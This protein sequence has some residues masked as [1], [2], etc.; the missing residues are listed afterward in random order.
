MHA[1]ILDPTQVSFTFLR[2][3]HRTL[4]TKLDDLPIELDIFITWLH[5]SPGRMKNR[6]SMVQPEEAFSHVM[7]PVRN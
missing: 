7:K 3:S 2:P 4:S 1:C 6:V 5:T